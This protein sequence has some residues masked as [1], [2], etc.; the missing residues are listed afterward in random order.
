VA[1]YVK[2]GLLEHVAPCLDA[3]AVDPVVSVRVAFAQAICL[4][5]PQFGKETGPKLLVPII[6]QMAKDESHEVRNYIIGNIT[7][8]SEALGQ[9]G[10]EKG[11]LPSLLELSKDP[12]WRVRM[13]VVDKT[14]IMAK[15]LGV[16]NFERKLQQIVIS[17]LSDHVFSI[18]EKAC[19]QIGHLV[20]LFGGKWASEKFLASCFAIYDKT[21][22][23]LHR[24]TCLLVVRHVSPHCGAEVC[25]KQLLPLVL[26]AAGDDVPNVRIAGSKALGD[27]ALNIDKNLVAAKIKPVLQKL[28][29]DQDPD[30]QFFSSLALKNCP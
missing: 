5:C 1:P 2:S 25:E 12:K 24:M 21:T 29:K 20:K 14:A 16:K 11:I 6:Q 9:A 30:V 19:E 8:I 4:L 22:N 15:H 17:S 26:Q 10:I 3:L 18:R 7:D 28:T 23:Y 13:A 27:L